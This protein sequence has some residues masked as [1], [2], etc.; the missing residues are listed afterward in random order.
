MLFLCILCDAGGGDA[1]G[2]QYLSEGITAQ[3]VAA[4]DAARSIGACSA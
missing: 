2:K 1:A 3:T 4:V